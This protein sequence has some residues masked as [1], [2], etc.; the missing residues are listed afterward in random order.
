VTGKYTLTLHIR[1]NTLNIKAPKSRNFKGRLKGITMG[2]ILRETGYT[3]ENVLLSAVDIAKAYGRHKVLGGVSLSIR[4][5]EAV[6][7]VGE[8]GCGKSTLIRVLCGMTAPTGGSITVRPGA[9]LALI[10]DRYEGISMT[11]RKFLRH[12][13]ALEGAEWSAAEGYYREFRLE[14]MLD[15]PMKYLSKGTLQKIAAIQA[16]AGERDA[17]DRKSTRLNSSHT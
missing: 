14:G 4:K 10:P 7:L 9:R 12:M 17:L 13:L 3:M 5:G 6:A 2:R 1:R 16:L 8:N 15:T 11:A